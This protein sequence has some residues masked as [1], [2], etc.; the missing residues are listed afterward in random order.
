MTD[1]KLPIIH[2]RI[3]DSDLAFAKSVLYDDAFKRVRDEKQ[4][5]V[6]I[7]P[8][9]EEEP[10]FRV[11]PLYGRTEHFQSFLQRTRVFRLGAYSNERT[12]VKIVLY[13]QIY[14]DPVVVTSIEL[15]LWEHSE[16]I[17]AILREIITKMG[18]PT[19]KELID[20]QVERGF[21]D[22]IGIIDFIKAILDASSISNSLNATY[23][24]SFL[25]SIRSEI[26]NTKWYLDLIPQYT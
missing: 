16:P 20:R 6:S 26:G 18:F 13:Y 12:A 2:F 19:G 24:S 23:G 15:F 5:L 22:P 7:A 11:H 8:T 17:D 21:R 10:S 1:V 4:L 3:T 25:L 9:E 14:F